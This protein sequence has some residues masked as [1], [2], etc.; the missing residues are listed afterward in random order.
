MTGKADREKR[1]HAQSAGQ[2]QHVARASVMLSF[3]QAEGGKKVYPHPHKA[4]SITH[5]RKR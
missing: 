3:W 5:D 4:S 2:A 1:E